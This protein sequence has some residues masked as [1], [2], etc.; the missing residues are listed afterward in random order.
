MI[1]LILIPFVNVFCFNIILGWVMRRLDQIE[2]QKKYI[3]ANSL[4]H[5][6]DIVTVYF[7]GEAERCTLDA[8]LYYVICG[9]WYYK[10]KPV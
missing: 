8:E 10:G 1:I 5:S 6:N 9:A 7:L 4:I 2:N 3:I